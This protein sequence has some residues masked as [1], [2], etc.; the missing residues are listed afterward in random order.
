MN[1]IRASSTLRV[2]RTIAFICGFFLLAA[3][4]VGAQDKPKRET[5]QA[6]AM[7]Q[8]KASGKTFHVTVNI[9][10]YSTPEDQKVLIDAFN[11]GG[12][13][14]LV[15]TCGPQA[16]QRQLDCRRQIQGRQKPSGFLRELR[17]RSL[18]FGE[19]H[20]AEMN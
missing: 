10:S 20:G 8:L 15:K 6:T 19:H 18:A 9:E 14:L 11:A 16:K 3:V 7:G 1:K 2:S 4:K 12:H 13:D 17:L 5:I